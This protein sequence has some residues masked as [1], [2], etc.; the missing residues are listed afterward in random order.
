MLKSA[1]W[2]CWTLSVSHWSFWQAFITFIAVNP[3]T[4]PPHLTP[5]HP[6]YQNTKQAFSL[7]TH[8][9]T[10]THT[11]MHAHTHTHTHIHTH[12]GGGGG[13][14]RKKKNWGGEGLF[15]TC[16]YCIFWNHR[17]RKTSSLCMCVGKKMCV[18][19][20]GSLIMCLHSW[21]RWMYVHVCVYDKGVWACAW[22][23]FRWVM[24]VDQSKVCVCVSFDH[25][26]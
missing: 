19:G 12:K 11:H 13:G 10:H 1:L 23:K 7:C 15:L 24:G 17:Y 5:K 9:L 8:T 25:V 6:L 18:G 4:S 16:N 21:V 26:L 2:I 20:G 14:E 3:G 22:Q